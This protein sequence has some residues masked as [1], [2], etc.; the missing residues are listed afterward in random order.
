MSLFLESIRIEDGRIMNPEYHLRRMDETLKAFKIKPASGFTKDIFSSLT[1]PEQGVYKLRLIYN[2]NLISREVQPYV[3][4]EIKSLKTI[5][6]PCLDYS[7]KYADRSVINNLFEM[8]KDCDDV[9]IVCNNRITDSSYCNL[10][11]KKNGK[12]FTP[13][14]PLLKGTMRQ[15]LI[16]RGI[17]SEE[18]IFFSSINEYE[19]IALFNAMIPWERAFKLNISSIMV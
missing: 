5:R 18:E 7:F 9:I 19:S 13:A 15:Y 6:V 16:D 8:R 12:W 14:Q 17:L 11:F 1:I 2:S 4:K 10:A 3:I